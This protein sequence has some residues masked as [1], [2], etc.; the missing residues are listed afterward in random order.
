MDEKVKINPPSTDQ[1]KTLALFCL[2]MGIVSIPTS[3]IVFGALVGFIGIYFGIWHFRRKAAGNIMAISGMVLSLTGIVAAGFMVSLY[4]WMVGEMQ[5]SYRASQQNYDRWVG[6]K[7]PEFALTDL[8]G[9][10]W[11]L[12]Q[13]K[14][15]RVILNFWATWCP[16]CKEE[17]PHF[18]QL[19]KEYSDQLV[20]IGIS[21][22]E[23]QTQKKFAEE[24]GVNFILAVADDLPEPFNGILSIPKTF[25]IDRN[26]VIQEYSSGYHDYN[27]LL[28]NA[29]QDDFDGEVLE[30]PKPIEKEY[31]KT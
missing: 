15:K 9:N 26:G 5:A 24:Q 6:V 30:K 19:Q 1:N 14:D 11:T 13:F 29:I 23:I 21:K 27:A 18:I 28:E 16:P 20:I 17:F 8:D 22:E 3:F 7:V 31:Q 2:I 4:I 25:Y 12:S 10:E